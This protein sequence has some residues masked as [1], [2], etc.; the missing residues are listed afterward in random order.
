ME[1]FLEYILKASGIL[2]VFYFTY[3][4]F[5][6]KETFFEANRHFL[7]SGLLLAFIL[8]VLT[9][10]RY[11]E[12]SVLSYENYDAVPITYGDGSAATM[13]DWNE[14]L[15]L[16][17][18]IGCC[19]FML[20]FCLQL[21]SLRSMIKGH[22]SQKE[23]GFVY[24]ETSNKLAPFSFFNYI[25][26]NPE[27]YSQE[28]LQ[29]I[30]EHERAHCSQWHSIDVLLA[31]FITV[32]LWVN[33]FCW[34]YK[35]HIKQNLEF[36]ADASAAKGVASLQNYQYT[37]LRVSG[38]P[39]ST[40]LTNAF[41]NSLIKKR[42]VMLHKSK[43]NKKNL[44]KYALVLPLLLLFV[45]VFN[46]ETKARVIPATEV[47]SFSDSM[48]FTAERQYQI[49]KESTDDEIASL[50]EEIKNEGGTLVVKKVKRNKAGHISSIKVSFKISESEVV[51]QYSNDEG[52]PT[53]RF[54]ERENGGL[55][56]NGGDGEHHGFSVV[57][58]DTDADTEH[59]HDGKFEVIVKEKG[60]H[61]GHK[62]IWVSKGEDNEK[63]IE[64][65]EINGKKT[66][67]IDG[68]EVSE[69]DL[70]TEG[71]IHK[72]HIKIKTSDDGEDDVMI[73]MDD[74]KDEDHDIEVISS[75]KKGFFFIDTDGDEKPVFIIDGKEVTEKEVK[76]L[77]P[78][79]ISTINVIKDKKADEKYGAKGKNGVIEITTKKED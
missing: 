71:K 59:E 33:P 11:V 63:Q 14:I 64:I 37:L 43:S 5:L 1:T 27:L 68:K 41:Y 47:Y 69:A 40:Q 53:I 23:D 17:Y 12:V 46:V 44:F 29:A 51:G 31:H 34:L 62:N 66:I 65:K 4:F 26:Y 45:L 25:F 55:Y 58:F 57:H 28:E 38:V 32:I 19:F 9:I 75:D 30:L 60:K 16:L 8:P 79:R 48:F 7:L 6:K 74:D 24:V 50:A 36:L 72:R 70:N 49:T 2:I 61:K 13:L 76:S 56:I 42:I 54:G 73:I 35:K 77:S 10:T 20:K 78:D 52:I 3:Q 21:F 18:I 39:L 67:I 15:T 22:N